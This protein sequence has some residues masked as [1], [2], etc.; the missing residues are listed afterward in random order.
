MILQTLVIM[1]CDKCGDE[2]HFELSDLTDHA[3]TVALKGGGWKMKKTFNG[4]ESL[5]LTC[6]ENEGD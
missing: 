6:A 5:C 2:E 4:M 1:E 3:L